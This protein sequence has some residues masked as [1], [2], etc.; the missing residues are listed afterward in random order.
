MKII[1]KSLPGNDRGPI[2]ME[3]LLRAVQAVLGPRDTVTLGYLDSADAVTLFAEFSHG[4]KSDVLGHLQN[5]FVI[6]T[7]SDLVEDIFR[8]HSHALHQQRDELLRGGS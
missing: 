1:I 3:S 5:V 4:L 6:D 7:R 2:H 8:L